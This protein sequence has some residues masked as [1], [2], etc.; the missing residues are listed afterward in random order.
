MRYILVILSEKK[1]LFLGRSKNK[2]IKYII[3]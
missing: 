3:Q 2:I 1:E